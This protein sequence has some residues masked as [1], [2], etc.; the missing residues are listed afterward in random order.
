MGYSVRME[1][2][3]FCRLFQRGCLRRV[4]G[5]RCS[6]SS[7]ASR[8]CPRR[9]AA[10]YSAGAIAG[11]PRT[12]RSGSRLATPKAEKTRRLHAAHADVAG[13]D[14]LRR[15]HRY[16]HLPLECPKCKGPMRVIALIDDPGVVRRILEHL[17][18]WA[19]EAS[20]R[21]PPAAVPTWPTNAVIPL[22]YHPVPD[23]A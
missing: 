10:A 1:H 16:R 5:A 13:E 15:C 4:F 17:G 3:S 11:F 9:C 14:D 19:P 18:R 23:I 2:L 7:C 21:G 22:T 6:G 8:R 12:T 20:E